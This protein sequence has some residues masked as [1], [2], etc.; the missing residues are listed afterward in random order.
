[1]EVVRHN[2]LSGPAAH[3]QV[4]RTASSGPMRFRDTSSVT[5]SPWP[6]QTS[7]PCRTRIS[8]A[9]RARPVRHHDVD[10]LDVLM[11]K[12]GA[13]QRMRAHSHDIEQHRGVADLDIIGDRTPISDSPGASQSFP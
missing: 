1:V 4:E 9:A 11:D 13:A 7:N 8:S 12:R 10:V 5:F 3:V 2:D 6:T